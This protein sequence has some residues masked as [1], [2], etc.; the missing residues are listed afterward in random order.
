MKRSQEHGFTVEYHIKK[1]YK[2]DES[3]TNNTNVHVNCVYNSV[4]PVFICSNKR[5][6]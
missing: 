4:I 6:V 1:I 2:I 3:D 5:N